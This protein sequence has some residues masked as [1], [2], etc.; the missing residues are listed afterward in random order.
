[1]L[2]VSCMINNCKPMV[3][4]DILWRKDGAEDE[5]V[6]LASC[7]GGSIRFLNPV[8]GK[9][10]ELSDGK[11]SVNDIITNICEKF[12]NTSR[13]TVEKDVITF[14]NTLKEN[15]IITF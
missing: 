2:M 1:M 12:A 13:D 3:C 5:L 6:I 4:K 11:N 10:L 9:I 14:L 15:K 7:N 8:A